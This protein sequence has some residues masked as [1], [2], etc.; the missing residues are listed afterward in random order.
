MINGELQSCFLLMIYV[1]TIFRVM[2]ISGIQH[3]LFVMSHFLI[4]Y[5][6]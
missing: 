1:I 6:L 3:K 4:H 5:C 2:G